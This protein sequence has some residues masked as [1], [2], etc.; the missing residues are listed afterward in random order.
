MGL[1][2]LSGDP[3]GPGARILRWLVSTR[4][5]FLPGGSGGPRSHP[6]SG[7]APPGPTQTD[8]SLLVGEAGPTL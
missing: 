4:G 2:E 1:G 5:I 7:D 3:N 8:D 6:P